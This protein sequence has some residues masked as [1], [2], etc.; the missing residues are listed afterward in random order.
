M[1]R[2]IAFIHGIGIFGYNSITKRKLLGY[3]ESLNDDNIR[4]ID[5]YGNDNVIFEK[6]DDIHF[7]TVGSK[8]ER[9]LSN[10]LGREIHVTTRS[11]NTVKNM[12]SK[13]SD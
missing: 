10:E 7:A 9:I 13:F 11:M 12:I 3:L 8:I 1:R 5:I 2:G 4:I 6:S